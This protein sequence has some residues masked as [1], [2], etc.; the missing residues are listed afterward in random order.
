MRAFEDTAPQLG[1]IE[2]ADDI[3]RY[4][5]FY[6][7]AQNDPAFGHFVSDLRQALAPL[8]RGAVEP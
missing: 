8:A 7:A 6:R 3:V 1:G 2:W 4:M 5:D